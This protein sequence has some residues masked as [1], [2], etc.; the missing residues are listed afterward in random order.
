MVLDSSGGSACSEFSGHVAEVVWI[1]T[2]RNNGLDRGGD[3]L[4]WLIVGKR[5]RCGVGAV[6]LRANTT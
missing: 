1:V 2:G 4:T 3:R 6:R 5:E